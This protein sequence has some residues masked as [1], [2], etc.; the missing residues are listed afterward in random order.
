MQGNQSKIQ[1][2]IIVF[3]VVFMFSCNSGAGK[4]DPVVAKV[5][6]KR[7]YFS[8][9]SGIFPKGISQ[10]D[11][12]AFAKLYIDNWIKTRLLLKR[13]ELNLTAEESDVSKEIETYR[14][15]LL[16]YKYEDRMLQEKLD[17]IV[18]E[19]EI[20]SYYEANIAN[21]ASNEYAVRAVL[22][23]LPANAPELWNFRRWLVSAREEDVQAL[24]DYCRIHAVIYSFFD[25]EWVRWESIERELPQP[26]AARRQMRQNGS[27]E[28]PDGQF[29]YFVHV[30]ERSAPGEPDPLIFVKDKVKSIIINKRKLLFLSELRRN[31]YNDALERNQFEIFNINLTK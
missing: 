21:F 18:R 17:T 7:L 11:S 8:E 4:D 28:Q 30:R 14:S 15:S 10:E 12:L 24:M 23:K 1:Y 3:A 9:M 26:E 2:C 5:G 22:V 27:I 31:I 16:I 13:A 29:I 20:R 19:S 25:D 6:D